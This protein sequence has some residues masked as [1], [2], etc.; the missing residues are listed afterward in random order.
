[1][2]FIGDPWPTNSTGIFKSVSSWESCGRLLQPVD[3]LII[4]QKKGSVAAPG[5]SGLYSISPFS[6]L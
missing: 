3:H 6:G 5:A 4:G 2:A 1:M